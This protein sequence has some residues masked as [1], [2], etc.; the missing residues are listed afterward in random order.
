M[1]HLSSK[2]A[3][4]KI[5]PTSEDV[6]DI[7][8]QKIKNIYS[9]VG[10]SLE[11]EKGEVF[12]ISKY[13]QNNVL[14]TKDVFGDLT[15][16]SKAQQDIISEF[17]NT[18]E[19]DNET[20]YIFLTDAKSSTGQDGY[21]PLGGRFG[22]VFDS[23]E[24]TIAHELGHGIFRL[25]HPFKKKNDAGE[26]TSIMDYGSGEDF[27]FSEWKQIGDPALKIGIFQG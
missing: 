6:K 24:R 17:K 5:I 19:I 7:Y 23:S 20:Y 18:Q 3:K 12:D 15:D 11:I 26:T 2:K 10:V 27:L 14:E 25:S 13:L 1:V 8:L 22:F 16:Y 21:M 4:V 9:R